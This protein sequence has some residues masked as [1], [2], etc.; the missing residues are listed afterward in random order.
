M[1]DSIE[2]EGTIS[3][4]FWA[5]DKSD[6]QHA[7]DVYFEGDENRYRAKYESFKADP[8]A[9]EKLKQFTSGDYLEVKVGTS[10]FKGKTYYWING[11]Y[12]WKPSNEKILK[13]D[14]TKTETGEVGPRIQWGS[15]IGCAAHC[16]AREIAHLRQADPLREYM[17]VENLPK[18]KEFLKLREYMTDEVRYD[19]TE[20]WAKVLVK[21]QLN[22]ESLMPIDEGEE[23][24]KDPITGS[25]EPNEEPTPF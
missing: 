20:S 24:E 3:K 7:I 19:I 9:I 15:L 1:T 10:Y 22:V 12:E 11:V 23:P 21:L 16:A 4:V 18:S 2:K 14:T 6:T 8:E 17:T 13:Q 25:P 5:K